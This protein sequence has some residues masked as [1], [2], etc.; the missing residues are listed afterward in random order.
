MLN[1]LNLLSLPHNAS[2]Q[3]KANNS[4]YIRVAPNLAPMEVV[5]TVVEYGVYAYPITASFF[6]AVCLTTSYSSL[7]SRTK[8]L[9][10]C[11]IN[12]LPRCRPYSNHQHLNPTSKKILQ[13]ILSPSRQTSA[14]ASLDLASQQSTCLRP[15]RVNRS[16]NIDL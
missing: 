9:F 1:L 13:R 6:A 3:P 11:A 7:V 5:G 12:S 15:T 4:N 2:K 16:Y 8:H 10:Q 14:N